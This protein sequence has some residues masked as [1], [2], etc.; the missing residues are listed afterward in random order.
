MS[1]V[2]NSFRAGV[3]QPNCNSSPRE[4]SLKS[5]AIPFAFSVASAAFIFRPA[6][7]VNYRQD[8]DEQIS[9]EIA[10]HQKPPIMFGLSCFHLS[11]CPK[12]VMH[13]HFRSTMVTARVAHCIQFPIEIWTC[14]KLPDRVRLIIWN[15]NNNVIRTYVTV[16]DSDA[17]RTKWQTRTSSIQKGGAGL[18]KEADPK[19]VD[20][21]PRLSL[22]TTTIRRTMRTTAMTEA[23]MMWYTTE[24]FNLK[25]VSGFSSKYRSVCS[26][27]QT[28]S[29][30]ALNYDIESM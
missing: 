5:F 12:D 23:P 26:T 16:D 2:S 25:T 30:I 18:C 11:E 3:R 15:S 13:E 22:L 9:G 8:K 24:L 21:L 29:F 7:T 14:M 6:I 1:F 4:L 27:E 28:Y 20:F 10:L 17:R 19:T